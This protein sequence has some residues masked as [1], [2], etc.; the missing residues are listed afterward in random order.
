MLVL[1]VLC[2]EVKPVSEQEV[3]K[4]LSAFDWGY[5]FAD[6]FRRISNGQ[7][8]LQIIE[9]IVYQ[10]WKI[11]PDKAVQLWNEF[12]PYVCEDKMTTPSFIFK[13]QWQD[14]NA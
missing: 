8:E 9:N 1:E 5:E 4:R 6:D 11:N 2:K 14:Q 3:I 10:L 7:R 13:L 12:C